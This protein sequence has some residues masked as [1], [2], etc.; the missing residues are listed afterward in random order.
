MKKG[1]FKYVLLIG[2]L[3]LLAD[4]TPDD[5]D[6]RD[7]DTVDVNTITAVK[8]KPNHSMVLADGKATLDLRPVVYQDK[9]AVVAH[10]VDDAWL[11]YRT[12]SGIS[13][14]RYFKTDDPRLCGTTLQVYAKLKEKEVYS[15]TVDITVTTPL[16]PD[17]NEIDIP[18]VFHI[19][20]TTED[21]VSYGGE[22]SRE[23]VEQILSKLNNAFSGLVSVN[24]TGVDTKVRFKPALYDPK[25]KL[26]E[27][28]GINPVEVEKILT[29]NKYEDFLVQEKLIWEPARYMN[30]W[31]ISDGDNQVSKF[32]YNISNACKPYYK[33]SGVT[34]LPQGMQLGDYQESNGWL[35]KEVGLIYKL[36]LFNQSG[37]VQGREEENE[38]IYYVGNY[39]GLVPTWGYMKWGNPVAANDY[40]TDTQK[41]LVDTGEGADNTGWKKKGDAGFEFTAENI[42]DDQISLHR[43]VTKDQCLRMRW[44][45]ENCPERAAWKS[46]FAF[47]GKQ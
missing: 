15:D 31:L 42:M 7:N 46:D 27:E 9:A 26:L 33:N 2:S 30:I 19:V 22:F 6:Y 10:R 20:Q 24:P 17:L 23:R 34:D 12:V 18:V 38:F 43:S 29:D 32:C 5:P 45:L 11:E 44:I 8:L 40:C 35:P 25:G 36:Q 47:T 4:C 21:I 39:L 14:D 1:L 28:P 37:W 41:Y 13:L 3:Q 16:N